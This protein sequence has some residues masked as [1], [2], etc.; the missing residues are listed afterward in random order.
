M[1]STPTL[2]FQAGVQ[3]V[4]AILYLWVGRTVIQRDVEGEAKRANYLFAFFWISLGLVFLMVPLF[5]IPTQ[6]LGYRDLAFAVTLLNLLLILIAA[7]VWGLVYFLV[8]LYTGS[9]R[10]FWPITIFYLALAVILVYLVAWINPTGFKDDGTLQYSQQQFTGL[11]AIALGLMFSLPVVLAALAYGS[12]FF[13]VHDP[14]PRYRIG[15]VAGAFLIQFGW[16][17]L[18]SVLQLQSKYPNSLALSLVGSL[19]AILAAVAILL[20]YRPP[21]AIRERLEAAARSGGG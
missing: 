2:L 11:P 21:R 9:R 6:I 8:Y 13:R 1:A 17:T 20:A 10:W 3:L 14:T 18:S 7:A 12:L 5:T 19:L 15:M 16:S 4:S